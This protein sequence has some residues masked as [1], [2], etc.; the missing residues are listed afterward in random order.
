L[1]VVNGFDAARIKIDAE[2]GKPKSLGEYLDELLPDAERM[3]RGFAKLA[4][5]LDIK[6]ARQ[7]AREER[8]RHG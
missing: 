1:S 4:A 6:I 2:N 5:N 8:N 7:K 3:E